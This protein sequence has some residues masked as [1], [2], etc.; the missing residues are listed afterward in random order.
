MPANN[1]Q[2]EYLQQTMFS[3]S[4]LLSAAGHLDGDIGNRAGWVDL[5][6]GMLFAGLQVAASC[7]HQVEVERFGKKCADATIEELEMAVELMC[8]QGQCTLRLQKAIA[9]KKAAVN[10]EAAFDRVM[11]ED[12]KKAAPPCLRLVGVE[13]D[14]RLTEE[15]PVEN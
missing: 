1:P 6:L 9:L 11:R 10:A 8:Q 7:E 13:I 3:R 15:A 12:D 2:S 14:Q 4:L 5:H